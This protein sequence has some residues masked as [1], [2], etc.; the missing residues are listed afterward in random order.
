MLIFVR[1]TAGA[2]PGGEGP[3]LADLLK[4]LGCASSLYFLRPLGVALGDAH[5]GAAP[6]L[7]SAAG[8]GSTSA[9]PSIAG[10]SLVRADGP[11]ARRLFPDT[12]VV[13]PTKWAPLQQKRVRYR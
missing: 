8:S 6:E 3:L 2:R 7:A 4:R 1:F 12:P 11:G 10:V 9:A 5:E 13:P